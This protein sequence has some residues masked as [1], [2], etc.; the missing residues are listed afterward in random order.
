MGLVSLLFY[1]GLGFE[2]GIFGFESGGTG[3]V[4]HGERQEGCVG[5][6]RGENQKAA[7]GAMAVALLKREASVVVVVLKP[8]KE[9]VGLSLNACVGY[10]ALKGKGSGDLHVLYQFQRV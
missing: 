8:R 3:R 6:G 4:G 5:D 7:V 2:Q 10:E 1:L 9:E